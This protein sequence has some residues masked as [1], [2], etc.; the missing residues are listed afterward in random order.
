[1]TDISADLSAPTDVPDV[2]VVSIDT[3]TGRLSRIR[4]RF[5]TFRRTRPCWGSLIRLG[6]AGVVARPRRGGA[7]GL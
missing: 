1:M 2:P 3:P 6:G 4:R 7:I 5:T